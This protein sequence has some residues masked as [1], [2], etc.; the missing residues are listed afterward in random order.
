MTDIAES[1][2]FSAALVSRTHDDRA[3]CVIEDMVGHVEDNTAALEK[4]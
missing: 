3:R 4:K 1:V 2:G